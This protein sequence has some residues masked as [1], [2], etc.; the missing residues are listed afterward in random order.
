MKIIYWHRSLAKEKKTA[1]FHSVSSRYK[2]TQL[3]GFGLLKVFFVCLYVF[4]LWF[5][6]QLNVNPF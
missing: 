2:V 1:L 4:V 5:Q 6:I 3:P